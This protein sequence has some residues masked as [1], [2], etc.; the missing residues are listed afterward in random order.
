[1]KK[2][3]RVVLGALCVVLC[4]GVAFAASGPLLVPDYN[5][6]GVIDLSVEG[7]MASKGEPFTVWLNDDDD[8]A[9][10]EGGAEAAIS[11]CTEYF[12]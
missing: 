9:G 5:R 7:A 10:T 12:L 4:A 1:M 2:M 6:D 11:R 8:D 3:M